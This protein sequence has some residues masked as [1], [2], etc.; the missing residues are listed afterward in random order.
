MDYEQIVLDTIESIKPA[1]KAAIAK[2]EARQAELAKPPGSLGLLEE[3]S[4]RIAGMTGDVINEINSGCVAV[5]CS[6]N[7]VAEEGV[8]SAE[9]IISKVKGGEVSESFLTYAKERTQVIYDLGGIRNYK[10][11][12]GFCNKLEAFLKESR[13]KDL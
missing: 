1:D 12:K 3:I 13:K 7:G 6:D 10:K 11:Y 2:A 8:A 5:F 4:I 9:N